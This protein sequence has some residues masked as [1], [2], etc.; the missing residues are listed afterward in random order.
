MTLDELRR[1]RPRDRF[2]QASALGFL[3]LMVG[4]WLFVDFEWPEPDRAVRNLVRFSG[5]IAPTFTWAWWT[6]AVRFDVVA[7][8]VALALVGTGLAAL[9]GLGAVLG[10]SRAVASS[11]PF[12]I[13][14]RGPTFGWTVLRGG[15]RFV[16]LF[17]RAI[18][19][20]VWAFLL[21]T[22]L[23]LSAW[24]AVLALAL[25]NAG[26]LGKLFTE[27]V[28]DVEPAAP[29]ALRGLGAGRLATL[30]AGVLPQVQRRWLLYV[31]VRWESCIR[32]ATVVGL[33]GVVSLGWAIRE[34][35]ARTHYDEMVA[36]VAVSSLLILVGDALSWWLR[37]A[38]RAR[39]S[40]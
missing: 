19:E 5:E 3:A 18:P 26:I 16:L 24:P 23:G 38:G 4:A 12:A 17:L 34:A 1:A 21:V 11:D 39:W 20:Y 28:D 6:T 33:V 9:G 30:T 14:P 25:H 13:A 8:T 40:R 29:R 2:L 35:R 15:V 36:L 7:N 31:F 22:L 10:A 32:E 37:A 27:T